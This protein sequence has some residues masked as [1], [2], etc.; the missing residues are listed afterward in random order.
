VNWKIVGRRLSWLYLDNDS[1]L[2]LKTE[3]YQEN[4]QNSK[5][6]SRDTNGG[7]WRQKCVTLARH[8]S[9]YHSRMNSME[10][11]SLLET[12]IRSF[13]EKNF[14]HFVQQ[15]GSLNASQET[16]A[17]TCLEANEPSLYLRPICTCI[18]IVVVSTRLRIGLFKGHFHRALLQKLCSIISVMHSTCPT[19]LILPGLIISILLGGD[20]MSRKPLLCHIFQP[21][22]ILSLLRAILFLLRRRKESK[23]KI[24]YKMC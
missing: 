17:N 4:P 5:W 19:K 15:R 24:L 3:E 20:Y 12:D 23:S 8:Q 14:Q 9:P 6:P 10:Q 22:V 13:T 2:L 16:T 1:A 7:P 11:N 21:V 18:S